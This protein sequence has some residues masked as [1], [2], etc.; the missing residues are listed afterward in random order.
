M[1]EDLTTMTLEELLI[2]YWNAMPWKARRGVNK[3]RSIM[4]EANR[5]DAELARLRTENAHLLDERSALQVI[6]KEWI[7][8]PAPAHVDGDEGSD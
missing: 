5:R 4:D 6:V 1:R 3:R 7:H 2:A 8:P